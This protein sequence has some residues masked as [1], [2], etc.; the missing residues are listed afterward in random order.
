M[1]P[2][3]TLKAK[4]LTGQALP[5]ATVNIID[6]TTGAIIATTVTDADGNYQVFVP[7]GGPYILQA[8]KGGI[9]V[10]QITS[11]VEVGIEYDL[12]TAD[13]VT[14]AA[15]LIAQAMMDA[16]DNPADI[17]CAAIIADQIGRAHV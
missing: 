5:G 16:G 4:D 11:Q 2:E 1:V 13:C 6:L 10:Q 17:N 3:G 7:E 15:A 8:I 14:T 12:G 9:K